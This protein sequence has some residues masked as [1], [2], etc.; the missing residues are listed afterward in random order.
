VR[1][2]AGPRRCLGHHHRSRRAARQERCC[3]RQ[4]RRTRTDRPC[5]A[6]SRLTRASFNRFNPARRW[7]RQSHL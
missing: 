1:R 6:L 5:R 3:G 7:R 4:H 2:T